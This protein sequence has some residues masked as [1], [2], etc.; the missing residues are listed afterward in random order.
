MSPSY[1]RH[2]QE[3]VI[4]FFLSLGLW[5]QEEGV[6][7]FV[8]TKSDETLRVSIPFKDQVSVNIAKRQMRDLSSKIGV[9]DYSALID[10][11]LIFCDK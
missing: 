1:R 4:R 9:R 2:P 5:L 3:K 10:F 8:K 7:D 6:R 11:R